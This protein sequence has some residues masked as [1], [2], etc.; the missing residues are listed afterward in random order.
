MVSDVRRAIDGGPWL[1]I[2]LALCAALRVETC[3]TPFQVENAARERFNYPVPLTVLRT[4]YRQ[5]NDFVIGFA[6]VARIVHHQGRAAQ[7]RLPEIVTVEHTAAVKGDRHQVGCVMPKLVGKIKRYD[8]CGGKI[9][10]ILP[11]AQYATADGIAPKLLQFGR[12]G[13]RDGRQ[14][15]MACSCAVYASRQRSASTRSASG[16][17]ARNAAISSAVAGGLPVVKFKCLI[18]HGFAFSVIGASSL[19]V[20]WIDFKPVALPRLALI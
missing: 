7:Y 12:N 20:S 17:G 2:G 14:N 1:L 11:F 18:P 3:E 8:F 10:K 13:K 19:N 5:P 9:A 4:A 6:E 16:S 15:A